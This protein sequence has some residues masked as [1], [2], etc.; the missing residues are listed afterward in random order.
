[1]D[2]R[3]TWVQFLETE[4]FFLFEFKGH[5]YQRQ[6]NAHFL[7]DGGFFTLPI[8]SFILFKLSKQ[9]KNALCTFQKLWSLIKDLSLVASNKFDFFL[10]GIKVQPF[11]K[12]NILEYSESVVN[13]EFKRVFERVT[14]MSTSYEQN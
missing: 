11:Q 3:E 2:L 6:F 4:L 7:K 5:R 9:A 12:H 13:S 1:M 14:D 10:V 8:E